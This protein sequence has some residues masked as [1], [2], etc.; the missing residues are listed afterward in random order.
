MFKRTLTDLSYGTV[1]YKASY[2]FVKISGSPKP[3]GV[4]TLLGQGMIRN[5]GPKSTSPRK[6]YHHAADPNCERDGFAPAITFCPH[7]I[8]E[9]RASVNPL[10]LL[11][12][13]RGLFQFLC[14]CQYHI[15]ACGK[16]TVEK[17]K[18]PLP[19]ADGGRT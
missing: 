11:T 10:T 1:G 8:P 14:C 19:A 3:R 4:C 2:R 9:E 15:Q 12:L 5:K 17:Q 6:A 16:A 13:Q 7:G 18:H